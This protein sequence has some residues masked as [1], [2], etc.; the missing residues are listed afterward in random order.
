MNRT[1]LLAALA[2]AAVVGTVFGIAPHLDIAV[3]RPFHDIMRGAHVFGLRLNPTVMVL[4][5][6]SMW[7]VTVLVA[8]AV[9][10]LAVKVALPRRRLLMPGRA[11]VFLI[12]TLALGPGLLTNL[13]LKEYWGRA[14]PI[15]VVPLSGSD[16]FVAWWDPR[17]P[18][19]TNCSF[20]SGDVSAAYWTFAPAALAPPPWRALAY[21]GAIAFGLGVSALRVAAGAHFVSDVVFAGVFMFLVVWAVHGLIYRWPR[22]RLTDEDIERAIERIAIPPHDFFMGLFG[23]R[24]ERPDS[25]K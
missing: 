23:K 18:C 17:G 14:R 12:A 22:T 4:R 6:T 16:R 25:Q 21:G 3:M 15:D 10:A 1:G 2:V 24:R 11:V 13:T 19:P 20:V 5:E 9:A 7:I 8:P